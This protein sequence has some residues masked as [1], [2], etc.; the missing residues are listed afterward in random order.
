MSSVGSWGEE[1]AQPQA[2]SSGQTDSL[3][4]SRKW[5][6]ETQTVLGFLIPRASPAPLPLDPKLLQPECTGLTWG[7]CYHADSQFTRVPPP[8]TCPCKVGT[9]ACFMSL[10]LPKPQVILGQVGF[11]PHLGNSSL[12]LVPKNREHRGRSGRG[13]GC[14]AGG[15][16]SPEAPQTQAIWLQSVPEGSHRLLELAHPEPVAGILRGPQSALRI[17]RRQAGARAPEKGWQ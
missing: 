10:P 13:S 15:L 7:A 8:Q 4:S 1:K 5:G 17:P 14:K 6:V 2:C 3:A 9:T 16:V 12:G 11:E